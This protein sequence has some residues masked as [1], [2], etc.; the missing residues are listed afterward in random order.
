MATVGAATA[1]L[2]TTAALKKWRRLESPDGFSLDILDSFLGSLPREN[3]LP[4]LIPRPLLD[5]GRPRRRPPRHF[6]L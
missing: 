4:G 1:A 2:A 3:L 5:D 6:A